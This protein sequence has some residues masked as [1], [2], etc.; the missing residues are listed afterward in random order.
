LART[1]RRSGSDFLDRAGIA[2]GAVG[3][4]IQEV[5]QN[6]YPIKRNALK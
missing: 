6:R 3:G 5:T 1:G 2:G 4:L